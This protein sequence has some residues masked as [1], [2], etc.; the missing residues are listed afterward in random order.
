MAIN[1]GAV[2]VFDISSIDMSP[3]TNYFVPVSSSTSAKVDHNTAVGS[4]GDIIL[5]DDSNDMQEASATYRWNAATGLDAALAF[6]SVGMISDSIM[7]TSISLKTSG[8]GFP[9]LEVQGH[10]HTEEAHV[11]GSAYAIPAGVMAAC[12]GAFGAIDFMGNTL[13]GDTTCTEGSFTVAVNHVDVT[14]S[15]ND[16]FAG[17]GRG[18]NIAY[19]SS[20]TGKG[21]TF[22]N[23]MLNQNLSVQT[24]ADGFDTATASAVQYIAAT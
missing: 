13:D 23:G 5:T 9:E 4:T 21:V 24:S 11:S 19:S 14:D 22:A 8:T 12:V 2:D 15:A 1:W 6:L 16:H 18:G 3:A 7:V 20:Y 10:Q 17:D